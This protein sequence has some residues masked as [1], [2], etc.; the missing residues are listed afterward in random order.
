MHALK[1][2][3]TT[4]KYLAVTIKREAQ[5]ENRFCSGAK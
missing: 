2:S 5:R 4:V 3:T 1:G